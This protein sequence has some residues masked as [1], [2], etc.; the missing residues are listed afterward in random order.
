MKELIFLV[1]E[2]QEGGY[3]AKA[4]GEAIFTQG[5]TLDE[6]RDNVKDAVACHYDENLP[7]IIR[8]HI[9]RDEILSYA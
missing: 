1:E 3:L 9:V 5:D 7:V 8:L 2:S 4:L 6:V